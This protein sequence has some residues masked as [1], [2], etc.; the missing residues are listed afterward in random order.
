ME[1]ARRFGKHAADAVP[2]GRERGDIAVDAVR[3]AE[4]TG[5]RVVHRQAERSRGLCD[6]ASRGV[7]ADANG[8]RSAFRT[9]SG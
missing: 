6:G 1:H 7:A 5:D 2:P 3:D 9:E 4:L 8:G